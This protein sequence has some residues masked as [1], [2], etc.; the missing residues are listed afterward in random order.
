MKSEPDVYSWGDLVQQ[1]IGFWDGVRNHSAKQNL[2][3]MRV[4]D[5]ALFYHSNIGRECV[6]IMKIV[7]EARPDHTVEPTEL[8]KDGSNPWVGVKVAPVRKFAKP[9]TLAMVKATPA[10]Q[11]MA[12][13][14][15]QRLSVQP[16][17]PAEWA[18]ILKMAQ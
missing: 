6:G 4:G 13:I 17:A 10:L 3:A 16:V 1:K 15:Y 8:K 12:L 9:V 18:L 7:A 5:E 14:K 2:N 11:N